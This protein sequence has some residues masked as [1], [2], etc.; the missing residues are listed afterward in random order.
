M[1]HA[2]ALSIARASTAPFC[3][4]WPSMSSIEDGDAEEDY[5]ERVRDEEGGAAVYE[6]HV[7]ETEEVSKAHGG[8]HG[9]EDE[10]RGASPPRSLDDGFR[11]RR[12]TVRVHVQLRGLGTDDDAR[13]ARLG[14]VEQRRPAD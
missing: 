8:T 4:T 3:A 10:L 9:G 7:R 11:A 2:R 12:R 6:D 13:G 1:P 5:R 14:V